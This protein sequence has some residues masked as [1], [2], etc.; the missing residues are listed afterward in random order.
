[1]IVIS[2][3]VPHHYPLVKAA[4][5]AKKDVFV[6]WPLAASLQQAEA[7][8][9]LARQQG[10]R[11]MVGLQARQS[12]SIRRAREI[13]ASG[14]LGDILGTTMLGTGTIFGPQVTQPYLYLSDI[15]AGAN[16]LTIPAGHAVDALCYVLGG[17]LVDVQATLAN[18]RPELELVDDAGNKVKTVPKTAHDYVAWTA[19][20]ARKTGVS[21]G[22]S[23]GKS[24][25][26]NPSTSNNASATNPVATVVYQGGTSPTGRNFYWE[27]TGTK[28]SLVLEADSGHIQM[29]QPTLKFLKQGAAV[30]ELEEVLVDKAGDF[31]YNVGLAWDAFAA[32]GPGSVTTFEDALVRHRMID[33]IY[34][35]NEKGTREA[36][37]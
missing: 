23:K 35:S 8:T 7:L 13:V 18:L 16:L 36:Y 9:A 34:K 27:I 32:R 10:V 25:S 30:A 29:Y 37:L 19:R 14:D 26:T 15:E 28:A 24:A 4:L 33:A 21:A 31:S 20:V 5:E 17:E 6:E 3:K 2:V 12:P 22:T 11:T 1:M